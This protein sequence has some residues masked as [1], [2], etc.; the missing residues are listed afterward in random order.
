MRFA[1]VMAASFLCLAAPAEA[2]QRTIADYDLEVGGKFVVMKEEGGYTGAPGF[3]IEAGYGVWTVQR[4][5][6]Q[7]IGEFMMVRFGDFD[8]TYKQATGGVRFGTMLSPTVRAFGQFQLGIQNDGFLN[9]N[10]AFVVMPGG[11]INYALLDT[12][13]IQA[14]VDIPFAIYDNTFNQVRFAFGVALP[15]GRN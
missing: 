12:L 14:M 4:W 13:D 2:Q 3:L 10:N 15:L 7:A 11:G 6:V 9:S 5:R 8:A 1:C